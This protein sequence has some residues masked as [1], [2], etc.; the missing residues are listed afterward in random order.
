MHD[1]VT[2]RLRR[3][4]RHKNKRSKTETKRDMDESGQKD[5][6]V[7]SLSD[8]CQEMTQAKKDVLI[9]T[10]EGN[11]GCRKM[12][13][14]ISEAEDEE[15]EIQCCGKQ[16]Q[17][18][19]GVD[20]ERAKVTEWRM[21]L[22]IEARRRGKD[23]EQEQRRQQEQKQRRHEEQRQRRQEEQGQITGQEQ[24]KTGKQVHFGDEE[25][26]KEMWAESTVEPET[27]SKLA[28]LRTGRGSSSPVRGRDE[29]CWTNETR[30]KGK[31]KGNGGKG[32]HGCKAGTRSKGTLHVE[33][34]VT[35]EDIKNMRAMKSEKEENHKEDVRKLVEM[36]QKEEEE[37][38]E[39]RDRVAPN[40]EPRELRRNRWAG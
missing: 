5:Q 27:T 13:T 19:S 26:T 3:G 17:E 7:R 25:Q 35:D 4:G 23:A 9:Q 14:M 24:G 29:R 39:Q 22:A 38:E 18:K 6:Q 30:R 32:E 36:M 20:E 2:S 37:Q 40:E 15:H 28:E 8:M 21:R 11:E 1:S 16:L 33:N 12:I 34:F 31:G 10:L